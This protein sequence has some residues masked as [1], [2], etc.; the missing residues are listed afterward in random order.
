[1]S[2]MVAFSKAAIFIFYRNSFRSVIRANTEMIP[3]DR[4]ILSYFYRITYWNIKYCNLC[5]RHVPVL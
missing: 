2:I 1:M 3:G 4:T 5:K